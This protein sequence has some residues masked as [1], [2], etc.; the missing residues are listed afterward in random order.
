MSQEDHN[1]SHTLRNL[2]AAAGG[3]VVI[4]AIIGLVTAFVDRGFFDFAKGYLPSPTDTEGPYD[5]PPIGTPPVENP[6]PVENSPPVEN[7]P[8]E[9]QPNP[10]S[11]VTMP[12]AITSMYVFYQDKSLQSADGCVRESS[13]QGVPPSVFKAG[14]DDFIRTA[15]EQ[16]KS[17]II[18]A[19]NPDKS[20]PW[21]GAEDIQINGES[22]IPQVTYWCHEGSPSPGFEYPI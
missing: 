18:T 15:K 5:N 22:L 3:G 8:V 4:A 1:Q 16:N 10:I 20:I 17:L 6:P 7:P 21:D 12:D 2:A 19:R 9:P 14:I 11:E 13:A